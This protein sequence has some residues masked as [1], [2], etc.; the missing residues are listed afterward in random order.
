MTDRYSSHLSRRKM[1]AF[2][3][4]GTV[5]AGARAAAPLASVL[6]NPALTSPLFRP[7][8]T[9]VFSDWTLMVGNSFTLITE[10]RL[11]LALV[12]ARAKAMPVTGNRPAS[13][14]SQPFMTSFTGP[15][16]PAGN[17]VYTITHATHGSLDLFFDPATTA[18]LN[19]QFN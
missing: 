2:V 5:A 15:V 6:S 14:R 17:R 9:L 7:L 8:G 16:L 12:L 11:K 13:L 1:I 3:A 19:A 10:D 18:G 4:A